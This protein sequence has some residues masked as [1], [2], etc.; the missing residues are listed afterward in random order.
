MPILCGDTAKLPRDFTVPTTNA[1]LPALAHGMY[2][3]SWR[4]VRGPVS[5]N[6][7]E[8]LPKL[9]SFLESRRLVICYG[10]PSLYFHIL[11]LFLFVFDW[12]SHVC[13]S[14]LCSRVSEDGF[15]VDQ[16]ESCCVADINPKHLLCS[17]PRVLPSFCHHPKV[18]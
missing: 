4:K 11:F 12:V 3:A 15:F 13:C 18:R 14:F 9:P 6:K 5:S 17:V 8:L 7:P 10:S 1:A 16:P 2:Q